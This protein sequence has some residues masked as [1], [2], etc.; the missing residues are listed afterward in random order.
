MTG[1]ELGGIAWHRSSHSGSNGDCVEIGWPTAG[2]AVR[3]SKQ[4][5]GPTLEFDVSGWRLFLSRI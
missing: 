2:V 3:D 1:N 4:G 5:D